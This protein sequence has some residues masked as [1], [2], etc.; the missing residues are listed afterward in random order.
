[1]TAQALDATRS[2]EVARA[3]TRSRSRIRVT[4]S[5]AERDPRRAVPQ[6]DALLRSIPGRKASSKF[7]RPLLKG[8]LTVTLEEVRAEAAAGGGVP[9]DSVILAQTIERVARA[10]YG[11]SEVLNATGV[12]LHTGL[13]RAPLPASA[14]RAVTEA[15]RGYSDL[16]VDRAT[17]GRGRRTSRAETMLVALTG[18]QDVLVVNNNAAALLLAL[19]GLAGGR[20]VLVSRGELI[21]IG[22]EFR[23]PDIMAASTA[24]LVEVGTTNRTR[25]SDYQ[26]AVGRKTGL[27]LKV[28]PS[29]YRVTGFTKSASLQ[30][31]AQLAAKAKVPLMYDVGSGLLERYPDIPPDEPAVSE[32]LAGGADLVA[33][34]GDKLM[35]GPQAG[36]LAGRADLVERL[37]RHP[38]ARALRVD[39]MTVAALE[40]V[41]RLYAT[42][43]RVELPVWASLSAPRSA[44]EHR[45][46]ALSLAFKGSSVRHEDAAPGGGSLP[47]YAIPSAQLVVPVPAPEDM[48]A[49]LRVGRPPV[50]CRVDDGALVFDLRTVPPQDDDRLIRAIRYV[51]QQG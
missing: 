3:R 44:I 47:G 27:V 1:M 16:E 20:E 6:L 17:G 38:L 14:V 49:R 46:K 34:S 28:H 18:A 37:R 26:R 2:S 24:K 51:L 9:P 35:G 45:V 7:G 15:A 4:D 5:E 36:I 33:F 48:A 25:L 29:N 21:E 22:G 50:F 30:E 10:F 39:K 11:I 23:L 12:V 41:L 40:A 32:A 13:G 19:A 42:E 8:A 43:R 31:L